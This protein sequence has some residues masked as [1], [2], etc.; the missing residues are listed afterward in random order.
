M[1]LLL[2]IFLVVSFI[3]LVYPQE[4]ESDQNQSNVSVIKEELNTTSSDSRPAV[5]EHEAVIDANRADEIPE[6]MGITVKKADKMLF[7]KPEKKPANGFAEGEQKPVKL[8]SDNI[9]NTITNKDLERMLDQPK[10]L[11]KAPEKE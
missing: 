7:E 2:S 4:A 1:R 3:M 10:K 8:Q 5:I 9:E 11:N 6:K